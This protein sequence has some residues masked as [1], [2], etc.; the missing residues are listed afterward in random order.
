[1]KPRYCVIN[2]YSIARLNPTE[3]IPKGTPVDLERTHDRARLAA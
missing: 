2:Y 3:I 1:V